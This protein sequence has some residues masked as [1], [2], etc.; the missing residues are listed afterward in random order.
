MACRSS[1]TLCATCASV[2]NCING[3]WCTTKEHYV[4]Y[5]KIKQCNEYRDKEAYQDADNKG[6]NVQE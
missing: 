2:R 1:D 5:I 6:C 4:E 3:R